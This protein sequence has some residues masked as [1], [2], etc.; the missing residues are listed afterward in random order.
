[1]V[2]EDISCLP[3]KIPTEFLDS[4]HK[5]KVFV[6]CIVINHEM[7]MIDDG[8]GLVPLILPQISLCKKKIPRHIKMSANAW[9]TKC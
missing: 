9:S 1:M 5:K 2:A 7:K 4:I 3:T 6:P 8:P